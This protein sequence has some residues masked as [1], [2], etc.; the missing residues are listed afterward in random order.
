MFK[1][2]LKVAGV[3]AA[4]LLLIALSLTWVVVRVAQADRPTILVPAPAILGQA[5]LAFTPAGEREIKLD[6]ELD[7]YRAPALEMIRELRS[8]PDAELLRVHHSSETVVISKHGDRIRIEVETD[9]E[10]VKVNAPIEAFEAIL[11]AYDGESLKIGQ[12]AGIVG[13]FGFGKAVEVHSADA[14]VDVWVW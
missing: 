12:L 7:A 10:T 5:V 11:E 8:T 2:L 13:Q 1:T 6:F 3:M 9:D 14:D 4:V